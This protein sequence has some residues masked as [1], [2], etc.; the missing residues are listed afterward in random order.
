MKRARLI[1][2]DSYLRSESGTGAED[3]TT[4]QNWQGEPRRGG[5]SA[6]PH[7]LAPKVPPP[8]VDV[9]RVDA[10]GGSEGRREGRAHQCR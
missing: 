5:L 7:R 8:Q 1:L 3:D 4:Q 6:G 9:L 10:E 2:Y